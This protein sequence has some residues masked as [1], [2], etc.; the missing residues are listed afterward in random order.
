MK[1]KSDLESSPQLQVSKY[2][3]LRFSGKSG[4]YR[5]L[6]PSDGDADTTPPRSSS[7]QRVASTTHP[8]STAQRAR[9]ATLLTRTQSSSSSVRQVHPTPLHASPT[10]RARTIPSLSRP[11][12]HRERSAHPEPQAVLI[13]LPIACTLAPGAYTAHGRECVRL[14]VVCQPASLCL[15]RPT[16]R[17]SLF[18]FPPADTASPPHLGTT[19]AATTH[20]PSHPRLSLPTYAQNSQA[21]PIVPRL[22]SASVPA[23]HVQQG[24]GA[25]VVESRNRACVALP[26]AS[27]GVLS[28]LAHPSSC[29]ILPP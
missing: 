9:H 11:S 12:I 22:A 18:S 25:C 6:R 28:P 7:D 8:A 24:Q 26:G 20:I 4:T 14:S 2:L 16:P 21:D 1:K 19:D 23:A 15:W 13:L 29:P 17:S 10:L 3:R 5:R 27:R